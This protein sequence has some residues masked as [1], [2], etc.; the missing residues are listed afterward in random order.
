MQLD[1]PEGRNNGKVRWLCVGMGQSAILLLNLAAL[2][3]PFSFM[4]GIVDI[5]QVKGVEY[6]RCKV[7]H[8]I[9]F[10]FVST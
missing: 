10:K 6:F 5:A 8:G 1:T 3:I 4:L 2:E 7:K 9:F